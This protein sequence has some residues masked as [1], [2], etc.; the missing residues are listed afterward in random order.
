MPRCRF[1]AELESRRHLATIPG[2]ASSS[3]AVG[4]RSSL[5]RVASAS[6]ARVRQAIQLRRRSTV[7]RRAPLMLSVLRRR[8]RRPQSRAFRR[9]RMTNA[10]AG[11]RLGSMRA[12]SLSEA[13]RSPCPPDRSRTTRTFLAS[14]A[15]RLPVHR[16]PRRRTVALPR[17]SSPSTPSPCR[18]ERRCA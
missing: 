15:A 6:R 5:S 14:S 12:R 3:S 18:R 17:S 8:M 9:F 11:A 16:R 10:R 13:R 7:A 2:S 1:G 4:S